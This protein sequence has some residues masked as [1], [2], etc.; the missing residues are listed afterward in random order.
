MVIDKIGNIKNIIEPKGTKPTS[1]AKNVKKSDKVEISSEA[2]KAAESAQLTQMV[3]ES[4]DIRREKV[5][6]IKAQIKDGTY[7][8]FVDN[9]VLELVAEKI[10][11]NLLRK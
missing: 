10:A 8:K 6:A 5:E 7:N 4:P 11:I 2:K 3:K 1:K 9:K